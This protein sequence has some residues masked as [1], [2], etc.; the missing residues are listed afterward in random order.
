MRRAIPGSTP[1]GHDQVLAAIYAKHPTDNPI[2][3]DPRDPHSRPL[4]P[5]DSPTSLRAGA[6]AR[7]Q[8]LSEENAVFNGTVARL[9]VY[10][11]AVEMWGVE[12]S[13]GLYRIKLPSKNLE[14]TDRRSKSAPGE[15]RGKPRVQTAN[16]K[17][18]SARSARATL[19]QRAEAEAKERAEAEAAKAAVLKQRLAAAEKLKKEAATLLNVDLM[20]AM[21]SMMDR[22]I[23]LFKASDKDG[24]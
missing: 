2:W 10:D 20:K 23:E 4:A 24:R 14:L 5:R 7:I 3:M 16:D 12:L 11:P 22:L 8:G 9:Y 13:G 17:K 6:I 1:H 15:R 18:K 21:L 19:K